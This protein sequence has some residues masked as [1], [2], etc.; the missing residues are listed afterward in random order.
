M[1]FTI[2]EFNDNHSTW[3]VFELPNRE[4]ANAIFR[5]VE[6]RRFKWC[7]CIH[8]N[9]LE[10]KSILFPTRSYVDAFFHSINIDIITSTRSIFEWNNDINQAV[11][12]VSNIGYIIDLKHLKHLFSEFDNVYM[13]EFGIVE[14]LRQHNTYDE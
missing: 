3:C 12:D 6:K 4:E 9:D 2:V 14:E 5:L 1:L 8:V 11:E 13:D 7:L 10:T